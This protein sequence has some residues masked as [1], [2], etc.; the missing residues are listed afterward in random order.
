MNK[1]AIISGNQTAALFLKCV[2]R[3]NRNGDSIGCGPQF[4]ALTW[5]ALF[6]SP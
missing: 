3:S 2:F 4:S 5:A 1:K 6:V